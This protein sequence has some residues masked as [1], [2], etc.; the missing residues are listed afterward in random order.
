M[1]QTLTSYTAPIITSFK[2]VMDLNDNT[3]PQVDSWIEFALSR[4]VQNLSVFVRDFTYTKT[5]R[6]PDIFYISS[7]LKQLDV[8]LDFFDMISTCAVSWKSLRNLTLRFCQIPD[9]S[10]H[11]I[12]SGC[13]ILE[14]LTLDTCRLL[15]R[16]DLSKSPNLRRLDIN[17]QYRRTGPI[18]IVAPHIY[19]LRVTY[20]STPSTIVDV[21]SLS[22]AN[23]NII[24]S[25]LSPLTA[26][27]YQTMA[28]EML[29]KFHNVKRL[30]VGE[31]ILQV[32]SKA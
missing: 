29:S 31:T 32:Y 24:S 7:S 6:F 4:N 5:Y 1:N 27:R 19:Y 8:T 15:E 18:V 11:N 21:S 10:M 26:D 28:L 9:E 23:L 20:S 14:S 12:L 3:V 17:R 22:E 16:L 13:P 30:T 25:L 2:L